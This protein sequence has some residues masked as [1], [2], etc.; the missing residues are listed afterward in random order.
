MGWGWWKG[1]DHIM[2]GTIAGSNAHHMTEGSSLVLLLSFVIT[3][4]TVNVIVVA[5]GSVIVS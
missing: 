2:E 1:V 5:I 3:I 4:A